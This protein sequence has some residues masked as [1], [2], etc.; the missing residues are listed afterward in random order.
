MAASPVNSLESSFVS[1]HLSEKETSV[2]VNP[3]VVWTIPGIHRDD[4][5][6]VIQ[7]GDSHLISGSKD[8]S[9]VKCS[10]DGKI[11]GT[12]DRGSR[13]DYTRWVT[14]LIKLNDHSWLHGTRDGL[15]NLWDNDLHAQKTWKIVPW[16]NHQCKERNLSRIMCF[17][18]TGTDNQESSSFTLGQ[19]TQFSFMNID[20]DSPIKTL[21]ASP[22]DW[23][24]A[25]HP[26]SN[27]KMLVVTGPDLAVWQK[28]GTSWNGS[29]YIIKDKSRNLRPYISSLTPV[30]S[31]VRQIACAIFGGDV[32]IVDYETSQVVVNWHEHKDR[33]WSVVNCPVDGCAASLLATS[34]DDKTF[35][36]WDIRQPRSVFTSQ[37]H[38]GRVSSLLSLRNYLIAATCPST[39]T[40]QEGASLICQDLRKPSTV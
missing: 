31:N 38:V 13:V 10:L 8:G 29:Y 22:N 39:P 14:A 18:T 27:R 11:V 17:G 15:V 12:L 26:L 21:S 19:A 5:H 23:V 25:L 32:R 37:E 1:W 3:K 2:A 4:I 35:K 33:V 28:E 16:Q 40:A 34:S 7:L 9:L 30:A 20:N 6:G 24:Y 36:L